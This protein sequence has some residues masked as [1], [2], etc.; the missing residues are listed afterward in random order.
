M[1]DSNPQH[2]VYKTSTLPVELIRPNRASLTTTREGRERQEEM[3]ETRLPPV[4][5]VGLEPTRPKAL[6]PK[7]S[8]SA[9]SATDTLTYSIFARPTPKGQP[10]R[11]VGL[12]PTRPTNGAPDPQSGVS[13]IPPQALYTQ[14]VPE[15]D[16]EL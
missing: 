10:V 15:D 7:S 12:E 2:L 6:E 14:P 3:Q 16:W 11:P 8:A 13:T 4:C 1:W 9:S 5:P